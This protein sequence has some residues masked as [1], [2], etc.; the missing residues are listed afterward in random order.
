MQRMSV[1]YV[2]IFEHFIQS[3][4]D[5]VRKQVA[6]EA[7]KMFVDVTYNTVASEIVVVWANNKTTASEIYV[8]PVMDLDEF[9]EDTAAGKNMHVR[10]TAMIKHIG[11]AMRDI[12]ARQQGCYV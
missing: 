5:N 3:I 8:F 11:Q 2:M 7:D 4:L 1:V 6:D 9:L 12:K 10:A